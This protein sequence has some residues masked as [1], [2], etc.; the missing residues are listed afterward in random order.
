[1]PS[2]LAMLLSYLL[3]GGQIGQEQGSGQRCDWSGLKGNTESQLTARRVLLEWRREVGQKVEAKHF[4]VIVF[5]FLKKKENGA[6][7][8][9]DG[10]A[11]ITGEMDDVGK[12][13]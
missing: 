1:M 5:C 8:C 2:R 11:P 6:C 7:L 13:E 9:L 4:V 12:R 10:S 3:E